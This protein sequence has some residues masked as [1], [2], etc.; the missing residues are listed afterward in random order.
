MLPSFA[1]RYVQ[2][3]LSATPVVLEALLR[4]LS[5]DDPIW[6]ARPDADRF[7]LREMTAHLADWEPI[8]LERITRTLQEE[9]PTLP[10]IDE[11]RL[12]IDHDYAHSNP[13]ESLTRFRDGRARLTA[14]VAQIEEADWGRA[15][16][17]EGLGRATID[18]QVVLIVGHDAYHLREAAE[19]L[20]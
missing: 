1:R 12:A 4:R 6:D 7:T 15:A 18:A 19:R 16:Q 5:P 20:P 8:W 2:H 9:E 17:R 10:G 14:V 3:G 13:I 11:G